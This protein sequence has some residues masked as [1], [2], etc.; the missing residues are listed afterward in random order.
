MNSWG[1]TALL[2]LLGDQMRLTTSPK[3]C[4]CETQPESEVVRPYPFSRQC[5]GGGGANKYFMPAFP[6]CPLPHDFERTRHFLQRRRE[7]TSR[8]MLLLEEEFCRHLG[9][10][11]PHVSANIER[12]IFV[13]AQHGDTE[14]C[15]E[16]RQLKPH[17]VGACRYSSPKTSI[18]HHSLLSLTWLRQ[19]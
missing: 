14:G 4:T 11:A 9:L 19:R 5:E 17:P 15:G 2:K 12:C 10:K 18:L 16:R 8:S 13:L 3:A 7:T 6:T 1:D